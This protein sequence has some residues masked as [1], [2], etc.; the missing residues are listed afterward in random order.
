MNVAYQLVDLLWAGRL[1]GGVTA[2]AGVGIG[3]TF[4][5]L[6]FMA[7]QGLDNVT[8]AMVARA[9]GAGNIPLANHIA[10]QSFNLTAAY[11]AVMIIFGLFLTDILLNLIGVSKEVHN[12]TAL[13]MRLQFIMIAVMSFRMVAASA[14]Q[15]AGDV[16]SPLKATTVTRLTH[17]AISPFLMFGWGIAPEFG[18]AGA[19]IAGIASQLIGTAM[20]INA[21]FRGQS[22]L[23]LTLRGYYLDY[24]LLW[25]MVKVGTPASVAGSERAVAQ[26]VLLGVVA[27]FG[28]ISMAA[29]ALTRR[30]EMLANFGSQGIGQASGIMVGQN[31]GA[32]KPERARKAV[33]W[34]LVY[35]TVAK[36]V[37]G[38]MIFG[39]PVFFIMI[40][41][42]DAGVIELTTVWLRI[43]VI[44]AILMGMQM[45]FQQSYNT[46][47]DTMTPMIV[48]LFAVWAVEV[49]MAWWLS[50]QMD[51]GPI[52]VGW[53]GVAAMASRLM[54]YV[55]Y[56]F[57][58]RWLRVKLI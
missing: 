49:P 34:A 26:L 6:G 23:Q 22:K 27:P 37:L 3:H 11:S 44:A 17:I 50:H 35:V 29:Y 21:L 5:Q 51:V 10:V 25:K 4:T 15:A 12:Q 39:F 18:L 24:P 31:L 28:D 20:N 45:V 40:F 52:G 47:G 32:G 30:M 46:A 7:R 36:S 58:D 54:L 55:P 14:L 16:I 19:G 9:V 56:F 48:T 42:G 38:A 2:I 13:Y 8:R 53:A 41:T 57:T 33:G 43:Q 1:P